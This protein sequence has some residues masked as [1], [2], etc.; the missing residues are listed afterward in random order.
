[1]VPPGVGGESLRVTLEVNRTE[2]ILEAF[3][4]V[5]VTN[6]LRNSYLRRRGGLYHQPPRA[7]LYSR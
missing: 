2:S 7:V 6:K 3:T 1:M 4:I 5:G